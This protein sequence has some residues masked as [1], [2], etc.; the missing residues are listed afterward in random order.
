MEEILM[1]RDTVIFLLQ[2]LEDFLNMEKCILNLVQETEFL[3][4]AIIS[5]KMYLSLRQENLL[6]IQSQCHDIHAKGQV[7]AHKL[8]ELLGLQT[9]TIQAVFA[10]SDEISTPSA[11]ASK[12]IESNSILSS[13]CIPQQQFQGGTSMV[14]PKSPDFQWALPNSASTFFD[15]KD[16]CIQ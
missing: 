10:S 11:T 8:T 5:L 14:N 12:S 4:A 16:G 15:N 9:L 13:D 6:K 7:T 1:S 3:G 2:H